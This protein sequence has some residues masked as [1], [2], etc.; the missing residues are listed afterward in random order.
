MISMRGLYEDHALPN[1]TSSNTCSQYSSM[2][3]EL[4]C[5]F[6]GVQRHS[7]SHSSTVSE[8]CLKEKGCLKKPTAAASVGLLG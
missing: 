7:S 2:I 3:M 1:N 8:G 6:A 4:Y 5:A